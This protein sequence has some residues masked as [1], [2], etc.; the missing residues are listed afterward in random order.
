M[1]QMRMRRSR[2]RLYRPELLFGRDA[3]VPIRQ[4]CLT[5]WPFATSPGKLL[6]VGFL[7]VSGFLPG[8]G[9]ANQGL[10]VLG[11]ADLPNLKLCGRM[12]LRRPLRPA[13]NPRGR[14][15]CIA[16]GLLLL[17]TCLTSCRTEE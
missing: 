16:V 12:T 4:V 10:R 2:N 11:N 13:I 7:C 3:V 9:Y 8:M 6:S 15:W 17:A 5:G 1:L 14:T